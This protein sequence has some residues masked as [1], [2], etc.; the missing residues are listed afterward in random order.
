MNNYSVKHLKVTKKNFQICLRKF[1]NFDPA[2]LS[3]LCKL[4]SNSKRE[5]ILECTKDIIIFLESNKCNNFRQGQKC[6]H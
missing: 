3:I 6:R 2:L 1:V 5:Q 4:F